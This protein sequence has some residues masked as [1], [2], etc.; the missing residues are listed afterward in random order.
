M[1]SVKQIENWLHLNHERQEK[2]KVLLKEETTRKKEMIR[3]KTPQQVEDKETIVRTI[4]RYRDELNHSKSRRLDLEKQLKEAKQVEN[5]PSP[6]DV[7]TVE[8]ALS[9]KFNHKASS[10]PVKAGLPKAKAADNRIH[11]P[12][13]EDK[14]GSGREVEERF[15]AMEGRLNGLEQ[16]LKALEALVRE[17]NAMI[18]EALAGKGV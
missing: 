10:R 4:A 17:S 15:Q 6:R 3:P 16:D 11:L 1:A 2:F 12:E 8:K 13:L 18:R 9:R 5:H 14:A 7:R